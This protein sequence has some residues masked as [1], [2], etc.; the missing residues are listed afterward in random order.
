MS[1]RQDTTAA[2][3]TA[4]APGA[5][6]V[7]SITGP[8]TEHILQAILRR[9]SADSASTLRWKRPTLCRVCEGPTPVDDVMVVLVRGGADARAE[10][11]THGGVRL[12]ER[13]LA[14]IAAQGA[15]IVSPEKFVV[16]GADT[17][18]IARDVD[19]ALLGTQSRRLTIWLMHQRN[20]LSPFL[21]ALPKLGDD[22]HET[23]RRR[24]NAAIRLLRGLSI[25]IV[26]PP[27]AGKSTLANRLIGRDRVITSEVPGTTRDWVSET[28]LINGWPI[29]L[30]DT[31]G[32]RDSS[33][34]IESEAI[35]RG[36]AQ[37][38][39]ADLVLIVVDATT[40]PD[41]QYANFRKI[42]G[43]LNPSAPRI[44]VFNKCESS[45]ARP[46][47]I[48]LAP[49]CSISALQGIGIESLEEQ[50]AVSLG[51]DQLRNG[52]PTAFL[53]SHLPA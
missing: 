4:R 20:V 29:M 41:D 36:A 45:T 25:A 3:L 11:C 7:I 38:R 28:A 8:E 42:V 27:N 23:F 52:L 46:C 53:P 26:G 15:Q 13:V 14:L 48:D 44:V 40:A 5:I 50:V 43:L 49:S 2:I 51:L 33:C 37:A 31:A 12:A 9:P 34:A 17:D 35:R 21:R 6:A 18:P 1:P 22:E 32:I 30:T 47:S 39:R 19:R 10:I 24:S 16:A